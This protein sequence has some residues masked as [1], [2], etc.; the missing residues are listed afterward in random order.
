MRG[1]SIPPRPANRGLA[2]APCSRESSSERSPC[3][4]S[5]DK[6]KDASKDDKK[7]DA[8]KDKK[9]HAKKGGDGGG[10]SAVHLTEVGRAETIES[11]IE[12]EIAKCQAECDAAVDEYYAAKAR[13]LSRCPDSDASRRPF[14]S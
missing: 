9:N 14:S 7:R 8:K 5:G 1:G 4:C 6:K 12:A 13:R 11:A 10:G 3:R 2:G